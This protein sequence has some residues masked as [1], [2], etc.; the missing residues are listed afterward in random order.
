MFLV[1]AG[2]H[3]LV[4]A[5]GF[6]PTWWFSTTSTLSIY[7]ALGATYFATFQAY[8]NTIIPTKLLLRHRITIVI[9]LFSVA[10]LICDYTRRHHYIRL[11][12][13][14]T[15]DRSWSFA[16]AEML[17]AIVLVYIGTQ[18]FRLYKEG[19]TA[20]NDP[21]YLTRLAV[22]ASA[23]ALGVAGAAVLLLNVL[24]VLFIESYNGA[25]AR[26]FI[27]NIITPTV[28][29]VFTLGN[30]IPQF[31]LEK[32]RPTITSY[33]YR[34]QQ[35]QH[36]TLAYLHR[37]MMQVVPD[38]Y[39]PTPAPDASDWIIEINDARR[40]IWSYVANSK[41]LNPGREAKEVLRL[42]DS[43]Q[44]LKHAGPYNVPSLPKEITSYNLAVARKLTRLEKTKP[45][46]LQEV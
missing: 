30:L 10:T 34:R 28:F 45:R 32:L 4:I 39:L 41:D 27:G 25:P 43:H 2:V 9:T 7:A 17:A 6:T 36:L 19:L 37:R 11:F 15:T 5:S 21:M 1:I 38:V 46:L 24:A 14:A 20:Y 40:I 18:I 3:S 16:I 23:L 26:W 13:S 8:Y 22:M 12:D 29:G 33:W 44:T 31:L 35:Q 42:L